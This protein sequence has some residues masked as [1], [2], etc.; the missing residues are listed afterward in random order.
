M[1]F[2]LTVSQMWLWGHPVTCTIWLMYETTYAALA[3]T[4]YPKL[5]WEVTMATLCLHVGTSKIRQS[6]SWVL[7]LPSGCLPF[8]DLHVHCLFFLFWLFSWK[9]VGHWPSSHCLSLYVSTQKSHHI[10]TSHKQVQPRETQPYYGE[11]KYLQQNSLELNN[12]VTGL[13]QKRSLYS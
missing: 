5:G 2:R 6:P 13:T 1:T 9:Q 4:V 11:P 10:D 8:L 12:I 3:G 7:F